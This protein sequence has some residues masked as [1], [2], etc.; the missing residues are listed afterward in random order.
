MLCCRIRK[1]LFY[2]CEMHKQLF[3]LFCSGILLFLGSFTMAQDSIKC[4]DALFEDVLLNKL[5]GGWLGK[6]QVGGDPVTYDFEITWELNHQFMQLAFT[7]VSQPPQYVAK[8]FIGY[9]CVLHQY[10][11]HWMDNFG[12]R[13]SETLAYGEKSGDNIAFHFAYPDG[14]FINTLSHDPTEDSWKMKMTYQ[15]K[16]GKWAVFGEVDLKRK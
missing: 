16:A 1:L 2:L 11:M 6:G 15:N 8:V 12:G 5:Q 14:P 13:F 3:S 4:N 9:D 7:D 10:L